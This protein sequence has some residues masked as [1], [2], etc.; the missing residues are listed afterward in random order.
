MKNIE[1]ATKG[2]DSQSEEKPL[3]EGHVLFCSDD[4]G[5]SQLLVASYSLLEAADPRRKLRISIFT[6]GKSP[7][8]SE[9]IKTLTERLAQYSFATLE[10]INIDPYLTSY[11]A[12]FYNP[13]VMWSVF[14][15]ARCFVGDVFKDEIGNVVYLDIDTFVRA[16]L[17]ELYELD[18]GDKVIATVYEDSRTESAARGNLDYWQ[19]PLIDPAAERYFNAGVEVFN[20][21]A[22]RKENLV[23]KAADWYTKHRDIATRCDQDALNGLLWNRVLPLPMAYN[24]CD[25]WCERQLK[26]SIHEKWWRGNPPRQ[27]LEAIIAPRIIHFWGIKKPWRWNH[28][29]ERKCYEAAM[30]AVGLLGAKE[31]L[32]G[33]TIPRRIVSALFSVYHNALRHLARYRLK[34]IG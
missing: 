6:G 16:D 29:P 26:H 20:L 8:S 27:V 10:V 23:A 2:G 9:H 31:H 12:A 5:F 15:W 4:A 3:K 28:R 19:S 34:R 11:Y 7:L 33:A 25:G 30:R 14:T 21:E 1:S 13:G 18:L 17:G 32:S 22:V 24:Y